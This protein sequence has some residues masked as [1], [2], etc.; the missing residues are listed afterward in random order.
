MISQFGFSKR[1]WH[2]RFVDRW[3]VRKIEHL[4]VTQINE[5]LTLSLPQPSSISFYRY[6]T[7]KYWPGLYCFTFN[8][9]TG[10]KLTH[11]FTKRCVVVAKDSLR[12][13]ITVVYNCTSRTRI[14]SCFQTQMPLENKETE[15]CNRVKTS[16]GTKLVHFVKKV[17]RHE[18]FVNVKL[19][20]LNIVVSN[21]IWVKP[22]KEV[23]VDV[24]VLN[25][26]SLY[27]K[28]N[29]YIYSYIVKKRRGTN[30]LRCYSSSFFLIFFCKFLPYI[31]L[32]KSVRSPSFK[33]KN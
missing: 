20:V 13:H 25:N 1:G 11:C 32:N 23:P 30:H 5:N 29:R 3:P 22:S 2:S 9:L 31:Y 28:L 7:S 10:T 17:D 15:Q 19:L 27:L 16:C 26:T 18:K 24:K 12:I 21:Y 6:H 4:T 14:L 8:V 33:I